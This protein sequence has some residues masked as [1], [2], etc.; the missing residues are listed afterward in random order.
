MAASRSGTPVER[1]DAIAPLSGSIVAIVPVLNECQRLGPCLAGLIN[2]PASLSAIIV[3]DGGSTDGTQAL[4]RGYAG[5]DARIRLI[6][7]SPVG[8]HWNGKVWNLACGL[9]ASDPEAT[10]ILTL[11]ADVRPRPELV[12]SLL[13]HAAAHRLDA[14]SA[15]PLLELS[16]AAEAVIH[17]AFLA[18]LVYRYGLP[19]TV[20]RTARDVQANGQCFL[21]RRDALVRSGALAAARTSRCDDV[22]IAR[23]LVRSGARLGFYEGSQLAAVQMYASGADAWTNWPRSLPLRDAST[24][25]P[26]LAEDLAIVLLVQALPLALVLVACALGARRDTPFFRINLAL[27][28][29]RVGV[30]IGTRRAYGTVAPTYWLAA[31]ADLPCALRLAWATFART[32]IW[33]D[34]TLVT[35]GR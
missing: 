29:A 3:V 1:C 19:G 15:A 4:V 14:F 2:A 10:W 8:E 28:L 13:A 5:R 11:D 21:V 12:S 27:A 35:E 22:T 25:A 34:R 33:R 20:A 30:L 31:L 23:T 18:T 32:A 17:P 9:A 7:A 6:D 24:T 16:G 26:S